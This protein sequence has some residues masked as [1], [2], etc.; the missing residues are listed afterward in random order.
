MRGFGV[1]VLCVGILSFSVLSAVAKSGPTDAAIKT[2]MYENANVT[3]QKFWAHVKARRWLTAVELIQST[4]EY[5]QG[6]ST[7]YTYD[8]IKNKIERI[9]AK[10]QASDVL[11]NETADKFAS[12]MIIKEQANSIPIL[13]I[14]TY[15]SQSPAWYQFEYPDVSYGVQKPQSYDPNLLE[16]AT[17][18]GENYLKTTKSLNSD[19]RAFYHFLVAKGFLEQGNSEK[20]QAHL[21]FSIAERTKAKFEFKRD[22]RADDVYQAASGLLTQLRAQPT[23]VAT[24]CGFSLMGGKTLK[25]LN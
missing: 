1:S 15:D 4:P 17:L 10:A 5:M 12:R 2:S 25:I 18:A 16:I 14:L 19:I 9:E 21:E 13:A 11:S 20:A 23:F 7:F 22:L 8:I 3:M 24:S 6:L